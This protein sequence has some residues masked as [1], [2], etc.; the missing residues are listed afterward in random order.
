MHYFIDTYGSKGLTKFELPYEIKKLYGYPSGVMREIV[1]SLAKRASER[2]L[3]SDV[4]HCFLDNSVKGIA[5]PQAGF[6][7]LNVLPYEERGLLNSL[8]TRYADALRELKSA[9]GYFCEALAI[10]DEWEKFYISNLDFGILDEESRKFREKVLKDKTG[11]GK[12]VVSD[13]FLGAATAFGPVDYIENIT[14]NIKKR[15]FIKG[16]PGTGK[17]TF[18]KR[19][20]NDASARG[21]D[22]E[23]YHCSFDAGS[24][25]MAVIRGLD[26]AVFDSTAPH[27][28][29]P[30]REEDEV[31]DFYELAAKRNVDREYKAELTKTAADYKEKIN[32]ATDSIARCNNIFKQNEKNYMERID[33]KNVLCLIEVLAAEIF[34]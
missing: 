32:M 14:E 21:F 6:C 31:I 12:G 27:E 2:K 29:F 25:D 1:E 7:I 9:H 28:H 5:F 26:I 24:L 3:D 10:H 4:V 13:R 17:S 30:S 23:R 8:D 16:R 19:L 11:T 15:Y 34:G 22:A 20:I 18:L 33:K